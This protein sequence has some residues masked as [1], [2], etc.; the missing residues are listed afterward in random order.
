VCPPGFY[1]FCIAVAVVVA[2]AAVVVAAAAV[3]MY[4]GIDLNAQEGTPSS[5]VECM[6][7][8]WHP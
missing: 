2:A 7:I 5:L 3:G 1:S 8:S 4:T 6:I